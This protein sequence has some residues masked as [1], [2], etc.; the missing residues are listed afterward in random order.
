LSVYD[1][2]E[3]V[4][5][6]VRFQEQSLLELFQDPLVRLLMSRGGATDAAMCSLFGTNFGAGGELLMVVKES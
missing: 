1:A 5:V 4:T 2:G 3:G 6:H